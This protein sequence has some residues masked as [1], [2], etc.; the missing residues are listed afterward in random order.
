MA[1][2]IREND[3]VV[4]LK[5]IHERRLSR[6]EI[7][8]VVEIVAPSQADSGY[9]LVEFENGIQTD[10]DD[11]ADLVKL[12]FSSKRTVEQK[13]KLEDWAG[14][15]KQFALV[16]TDIIGSTVLGNELGDEQWTDL[17]VKH[18]A[19][20]RKLM[21]S[22]DCHEIKVI[23]DSFMVVFRTAVEALDF[24]L[25][26]YSDTGDERIEIRVGIHVGPARIIEDDLFG[27][28]VNYTKRVESQATRRCRIVL[29]DVAKSHID[30]EKAARHSSLQFL[31][32]TAKLDGFT[33]PQ[34]VW[35]VSRHSIGATR[36]DS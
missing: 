14:P 28:M 36:A 25:A 4:L 32:R 15:S 1:D 31:P 35:G 2:K 22:L 13:A 19:Q 3:V 18:F 10:F 20:A 27:T 30:L 34:N 17:L 11:L 9:L 8:T 21:S 6:G 5:D 16:F 33:E 24:A 26:F 7:G 12:N 29:S 23:G